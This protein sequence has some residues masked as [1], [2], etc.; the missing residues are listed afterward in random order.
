MLEIIREMSPVWRWKSKSRE[1][2]TGIIWGHWEIKVL[3]E[4]HPVSNRK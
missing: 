4:A 2:E 3:R 1:E